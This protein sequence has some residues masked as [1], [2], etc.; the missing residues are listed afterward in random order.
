M[1][2][3]MLCVFVFNFILLKY[4]GFYLDCCVNFCGTAKQFSYSYIYIHILFYIL[5]HYTLSQDIE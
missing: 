4:S 2:N 1:V 5:F 3:F